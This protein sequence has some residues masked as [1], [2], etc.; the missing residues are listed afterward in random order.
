MKRLSIC[1]LFIYFNVCGLLAQNSPPDS[2]F[3]YPD[4]VDGSL[5]YTGYSDEGQ[6]TRYNPMINLGLN[7]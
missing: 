4:L 6:T 3:V 2:P 5:I 7:I 1:T